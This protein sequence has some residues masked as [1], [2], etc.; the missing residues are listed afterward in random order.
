MVSTLGSGEQLNQTC[1]TSHILVADDSEIWREY[2][3]NITQNTCSTADFPAEKHCIQRKGRKNTED[4]EL[5][6][7]F[8]SVALWEIGCRF[9]NIT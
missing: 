3:S 4:A 9:P 1:A 8:V 2:Q 6:N 5:I 7:D